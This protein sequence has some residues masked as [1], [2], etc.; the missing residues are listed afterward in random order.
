VAT[1]LRWREERR[2]L[3]LW[4]WWGFAMELAEIESESRNEVA[5]YV[6]EL[7]AVG[8]GMILIGIVGIV[9]HG[10]WCSSVCIEFGFCIEDAAAFGFCI[11]DAVNLE[12]CAGRCSTPEAEESEDTDAPKDASSTD[13]R[14]RESM[15]GDF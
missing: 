11:E 2:G 6:V 15:I 5:W 9:G 4:W 12:V 7:E 13:E 14:K 10:I 3:E 1:D 8:R